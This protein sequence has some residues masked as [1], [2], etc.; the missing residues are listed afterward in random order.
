ML[1]WLHQKYRSSQHYQPA[2]YQRHHYEEAK[3]TVRPCS[4]TRWPHASPSR[5]V[6]GRGNLNWLLPSRLAPANRSPTQL[7]QIADGTPFG[8]RVDWTRARRRGHTGRTGLTQRTSAVY[9]IWWWWWVRSSLTLF[10]RHSFY[11]VLRCG[12]NDCTVKFSENV[13]CWTILFIQWFKSSK[14]KRYCFVQ[15]MFSDQHFNDTFI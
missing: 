9:A 7:H 2:L 8:I 4:K 10:G 11:N 3:L 1:A 6:T 15:L 14:Y 13:L 12:R 5:V